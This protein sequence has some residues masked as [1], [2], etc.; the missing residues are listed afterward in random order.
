MTGSSADRAARTG[1]VLVNHDSAEDTVGC[2]ASLEASLD[3]D[4]D[5]VVVDNSD[6]EGS[7]AALAGL[8]GDRALVLSSGGN[9]GYAGGSNVGV[10]HCLRRGNQL[11][12]LLNPDS[13]VEPETLPRLIGLLDEVPDCG[14]VGPRIVHPAGPGGEETVWFDGGLVDETNAGET[15]HLHQGR[16]I[17]QLPSPG[18][19]DVDYITGASLRWISVSRTRCSAPV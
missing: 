19:H 5:V 16:R 13:R 6:S 2:I 7:R 12:W 1:V 14:V 4:M 11:V 15:R 9:L 8:V 3:L 18:S 10:Q 17:S